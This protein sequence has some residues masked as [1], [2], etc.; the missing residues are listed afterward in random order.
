[1]ALAESSRYQEAV[2]VQRSALTAAATGR[3]GAAEQRI[4]G[5][6]R[7]YESGKPCRNPFGED[8]LP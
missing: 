5:N 8:E 7:L 1:M 4:A 3:L 6:L 2:D